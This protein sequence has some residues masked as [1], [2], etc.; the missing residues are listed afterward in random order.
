[1]TE[2]KPIEINQYLTFKLSEEVYAI[3]VTNIREVLIV[4]K[5]TKLPRMPDYMIGIIN[6]RG[7]VVP[8]LDLC[9]KFGLGET[10]MTEKTGIIVTEITT[11]RN[12]GKPEVLVIGLFSNMVQ[13]VITIEPNDIEPPPKIGVT[14]DTTFITGMGHIDTHFII[15]LNINKILTGNEL[16][17]IQV[18]A[19]VAL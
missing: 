16:Q 14:I 15:I 10:T 17:E 6:L 7:R 2:H 8:V 11:I 13:N 18:N 3:K 1:M 9:R 12:D 5:I 4:P 19:E